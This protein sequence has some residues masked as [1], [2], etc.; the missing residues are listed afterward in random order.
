MTL[1]DRDRDALIRVEQNLAN[2]TQNQNQIL[3][4]LREIFKRLEQSDKVMTITSGDLKGHLESSTLR[5]TGI[6]KT[7]SDMSVRLKAFEDKLDSEKDERAKENRERENFEREVKGSV[8]VIGWIIGA[9][10][11][12]AIVVSAISAFFLAK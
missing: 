9:L 7:V 3:T 1:E 11:S 6:E 4:D 10:S 12:I 2:A 8:K 5:W